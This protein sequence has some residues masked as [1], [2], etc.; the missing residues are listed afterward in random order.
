M[1]TATHDFGRRISSSGAAQTRN[2]N[3]D[4]TLVSDPSGDYQPGATFS[5]TELGYMMDEGS[6]EPGTLLRHKDGK[7]WRVTGRELVE[8]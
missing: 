3:Y 1:M 6:V 5:K 4:Y 7:T 8:A 2:G